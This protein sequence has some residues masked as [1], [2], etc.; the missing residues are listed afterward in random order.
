MTADEELMRKAAWLSPSHAWE[1]EG[2]N[3]ELEE[4]DDIPPEEDRN[5][6]VFVRCKWCGTRLAA[7]QVPKTTT[8]SLWILK[9]RDPRGSWHGVWLAPSCDELVLN[10]VHNS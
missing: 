3:R 2:K 10:P 8:T 4:F 1:Y 7:Q 5:R 6:W 9:W